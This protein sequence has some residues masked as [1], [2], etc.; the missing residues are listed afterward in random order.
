MFTAKRALFGL[1]WILF[2]LGGAERARAVIFY[3]TSDPSFNTTPPS[4]S[5]AGSGWQWVGQWEGFEGTPIG[6]NYFITAQ[7]IGGTVGAPF[8]FQ[9]VSYTSVAFFDDN[10]SD[11]RIV[12]VN[13]KFPT[14]AP[15][16]TQSN[17]V[18]R[19]LVVIGV[20]LGRGSL[21]TVGGLPKGWEW[22]ADGGTMRWG[23]NTVFEVQ[24]GMPYWGTL[25]YALF[26]SGQGANE[27]DLAEGDSS[28]PVFINDGLGWKLAGVAAA[29]DG[30]FSYSSSGPGFDAA[31]YDGSGLYIWN[32]ANSTWVPI[33]ETGTPI[34]TGFYATRVSTR[35]SWINS[36]VPPGGATSDAPLLSGPMTMFL[37]VTLGGIGVWNLSRRRCSAT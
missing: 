12:E 29:V 21:V 11:L 1:A 18:G 16:Y 8:V 7:H 15:L 30:P 32:S 27:C 23:E 20:G 4:G 22:G 6:E 19:T 24:T 26:Q 14:W 34:P 13:G 5:L 10:Q 36:I 2:A 28:S 33:P 35:L 3:S 31:I 37:A 9:G 17:E 25:L